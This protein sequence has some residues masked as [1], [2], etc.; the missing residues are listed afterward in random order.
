[1]SAFNHRVTRGLNALKEREPSPQ[2][3]H[4]HAEYSAW[5]NGRDFSIF[6][7]GYEP[8]WP[9]ATALTPEEQIA[10]DTM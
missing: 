1:M 5:I 2:R 7:R 9:R 6:P 3:D 10:E 4:A 8:L